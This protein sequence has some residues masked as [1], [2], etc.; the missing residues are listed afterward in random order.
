MNNVIDTR[1]SIT[2]RATENSNP[3]PEINIPNIFRR[4]NIND[5]QL[6]TDAWENKEQSKDIQ[7]ILELSNV[8]DRTPFAIIARL[9]HIG[10]ISVVQGDFIC[11]KVGT[12]RLLSELNI[13]QIRPLSGQQKLRVPEMRVADVELEVPHGTPDFIRPCRLCGKPIS[14]ARLAVVPSAIRHVECQSSIEGDT[15]RYI[16]EMFGTREGYTLMREQDSLDMRKR[17]SIFYV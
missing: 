8:L 12:R 14:M 13:S 17:S 7:V 6:L 15:K 10:Q 5:E 2:D 9:C 1:S 4:W 11:T 3:P 16:D